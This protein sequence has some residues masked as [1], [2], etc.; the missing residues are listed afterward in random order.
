M[1]VKDFYYELPQELIAQDPLTDRAASRLMVL[2]RQTGETSHRYFRDIA[3]LI[4]PGDCL[5]L[6]NTRV[7]PA[8]LLGIKEGTGAKIELL[9]LK[10]DSGQAPWCQGGYWRG[11][12]GAFAQAAVRRRLG[13]AGK[14]W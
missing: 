1:N 8:R 3:G 12:R 11:S 9:L 5:V 7:I 13:D 2:D 14:A 4:Q 6:N 10:G